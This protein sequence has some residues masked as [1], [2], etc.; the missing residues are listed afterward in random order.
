MSE[1][2]GGTKFIVFIDGESRRD[3]LRRRVQLAGGD[4]DAAIEKFKRRVVLGGCDFSQFM[5]WLDGEMD[6]NDAAILAE[7]ASSSIE[8]RQAYV[9]KIEARNWAKRKEN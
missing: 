2:E 5:Q 8:Q 3:F 4:P 7:I 1:S 9:K 6:W